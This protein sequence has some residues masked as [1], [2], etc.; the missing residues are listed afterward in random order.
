M[1]LQWIKQ[2]PGAGVPGRPEEGHKGTFGT[3]VVVGGSPLMLG[4]PALCAT[5]ALR[6]GAGLV[7]IAGDPAW[8]PHV[9]AMQ[10]SA[11]AMDRAELDTLEARPGTI[12]AVGPGLGGEEAS[13]KLV[14]T[15]L[16]S[17][18]P[19]VLDADGL[20]ALAQLGRCDRP[21]DHRTVLTP[22]P[23][24]YRRLAEGL[25]LGDH[26]PTDPRKRSHAAAALAG[27]TGAVVV[28]KGQHT[29]V[30]DGH[31]AYR[32]NTGNPVL[33]T[34]GTGD[35]LTGLL[36][37]L[38]AQGAD[39]FDAAVRAVH[40]HGLAADRWAKQHGT[41]GLLAMELAHQLPGVLQD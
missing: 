37:G 22:H 31:R 13:R 23:G 3:V 27:A 2:L 28:L 7:K 20:N 18:H 36:A 32:N 34:G 24:E 9:L 19:L 41:R 25:G 4:A 5:A 16:G 39:P 14:A 12:L 8:L 38:M 30:T 17:D 15:L 6:S 33:A 11:T 29:I 21:A 35:V 40:A 10:P 1:S 26:D